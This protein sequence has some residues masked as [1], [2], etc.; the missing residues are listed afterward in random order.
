[1]I[2]KQ[3]D[4]EHECSIPFGPVRKR[5]VEVIRPYKDCKYVRVVVK[6]APEYVMKYCTKILGTDGD[7]RSLD[8]DEKTQILE[9]EVIENMAKFGL[10]TIIY[11]YKDMDS[12]YWEEL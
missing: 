12:D 8:E 7:T 11:A 1:M 9:T 10:R 2:A 5:Q 6:G 3:R 4:G